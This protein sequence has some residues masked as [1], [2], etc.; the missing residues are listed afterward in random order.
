MDYEHW[1]LGSIFA[2]I[3][4]LIGLEQRRIKS[5]H[6][7]LSKLLQTWKARSHDAFYLGTC[8]SF[9]RTD[10]GAEVL[11]RHVTVVD[12]TRTQERDKTVEYLRVLSLP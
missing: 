3:E 6:L 11:L 4:H 10:S 8:G 1:D 12:D 7:N 9:L 2:G 5:L